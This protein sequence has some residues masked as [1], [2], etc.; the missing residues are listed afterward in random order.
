MCKHKEKKRFHG[1]MLV[2]L[3]LYCTTKTTVMAGLSQAYYKAIMYC[4]YSGKT[5]HIIA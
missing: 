4:Q 1:L 5:R 2:N 3:M